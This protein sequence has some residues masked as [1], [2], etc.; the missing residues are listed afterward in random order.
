MTGLGPAPDGTL[1]TFSITNNGGATADFV[2]VGGNTC[3]TVGG[4]CSVV[5]NSP[6]AGT[7]DIHA[8]T[9]FSV[10]GVSL[11][12]ATGTTG[13]GSDAQKVYV[14]GTIIVR[15]ITN[16]AGGTGFDFVGTG[17]IPAAFSL[18]GGQS[19][20]YSE[21][22]PGAYSVRETN[23]VGWAFTSLVCT[24]TGTGTSRTIV[25]PL[26]TITLAG[27]GVVDCT[28]TNTQLARVSLFK[29]VSDAS[30]PAGLSIL[31]QVRTGASVSSQGI[32]Q[33]SATLNSTSVF[34]LNL[35]GPDAFVAPG[36]YQICE[37]VLPGWNSTIR[38]EPGAFVPESLSDPIN[39]DNG[40]V[41][42]PISLDPGQSFTLTV[43]NT[44]PPGGAAKTIGFWK[45]H[46]SCKASNGNQQPILDQTLALDLVDG[47]FY[48]GDLFVNTC[49]EAYNLLNKSDTNGK[50]QASLPEFNFASQATAYQLNLL[51][52]AADTTAAAAA[53]AAGQAILDENGFIGNALPKNGANALTAAEKTALNTYA[54]ILDDYNNNV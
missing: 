16:P 47:G 15:K 51:A 52:G 24:A 41:C 1:V 43:N 8:T 37:F 18:D 21:L 3:L 42:I 5:I 32:V 50:K 25:G 38:T 11:T 31:F 13:N 10:L 6:T 36:N 40:Y 49:T 2:P 48:I 22:A 12:R 4:T 20:T 28:Y 7:V 53:F 35:F 44:P 9:T 30:I 19:V 17:G 54:G 26:A 33:A 14:S 27:G 39:F 46:S 45:N 29:T 23:K 34:P